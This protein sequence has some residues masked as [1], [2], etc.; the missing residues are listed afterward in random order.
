LARRIDELEA[1]IADLREREELAK[2]RAALDGNEVM[3]F[4]GVKPG[5]IV[6]EAL[7]F[8]LE[9]RLDEGPI[10]KDEA[11]KRLAAWARDRGIEPT[12]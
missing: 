1:R 8:L 12:A 6:G 10:S 11:R 4:L 7:S 9:I 5:P 2:I 3:E